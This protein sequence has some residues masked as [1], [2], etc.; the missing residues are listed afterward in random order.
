ME[1]LNNMTDEQIMDIYSDII[2]SGLKLAAF[3]GGGSHT[4]YQGYSND[5]NANCRQD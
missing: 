4:C 3:K 2:E 1:D 5:P